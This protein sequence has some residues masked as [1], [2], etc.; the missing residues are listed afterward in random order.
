LIRCICYINIEWPG[1]VHDQC[2]YSNSIISRVPENYFS[3]KKFLLDDS[4]YVNSAFMVSAYKKYGGQVAL[5]AGFFLNILLSSPRSTAEHTIGILKARLP[6]LRQ[7]H[8]RIR[9]KDS[10]KELIRL[11]KAAVVLHNVLVGQHE[12]LKSWFSKDGI[13]EP[14]VIVHLDEEIYLSP[15][16]TLQQGNGD[17]MRR[18]EV[19]YFLSAKLQ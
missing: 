14:E 16:I 7:I 1:S 6:F 10:M 11:V 17:V 5:T 8:V 9:G 15:Y 19:H 18:D 4:A 12:L 2:I 13:V 3:D